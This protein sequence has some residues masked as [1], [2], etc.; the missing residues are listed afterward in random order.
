M[1]HCSCY[2]NFGASDPSHGGKLVLKQ[3]M[4][5]FVVKSPLADDEVGAAVFYLSKIYFKKLPDVTRLKLNY[6]VVKI[7]GL[8]S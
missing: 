5:R 2:L 8:V 7:N 3:Q 6:S 1:H 4:V